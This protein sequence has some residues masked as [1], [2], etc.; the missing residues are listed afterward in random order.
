VARASVLLFN[1]DFPAACPCLV[2]VEAACA[3][4]SHKCFIAL[5]AEL[6]ARCEGPDDH[7][8]R[9]RL[10]VIVTARARSTGTS[11]PPPSS[12]SGRRLGSDPAN[13][14]LCWRVTP[15]ALLVDAPDLLR[16]TPFPLVR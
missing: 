2:P 10:G 5:M 8:D 7:D 15:R 1:R 13:P 4:R 6:L 9:P 3:A 11:T 14:E 12:G 16:S